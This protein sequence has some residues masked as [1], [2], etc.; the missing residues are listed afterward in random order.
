MYLRGWG[1]NGR[2]SRGLTSKMYFVR[3]KRDVCWVSS[4]VFWSRQDKDIFK[5]FYNLFG[6]CKLPISV[7]KDILMYLH[8]NYSILGSPLLLKKLRWI[9]ICLISVCGVFIIV[10]CIIITIIL[11]FFILIFFFFKI[12][13]FEKWEV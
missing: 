6:V 9:Q 13:I 2:N 11:T 4:T 8:Y 1:L 12:K 3:P 5:Q 7:K 10:T